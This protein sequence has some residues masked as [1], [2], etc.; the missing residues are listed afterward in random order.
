MAEDRPHASLGRV[1]I[2]VGGG[3]VFGVPLARLVAPQSS[4]LSTFSFSDALPLLIMS[5]GGACIVLGIYLHFGWPSPHHYVI[6]KWRKARL[7]TAYLPSVRVLG[8]EKRIARQKTHRVTGEDMKA[9]VDIGRLA[10]RAGVPERATPE[11]PTA[12]SAPIPRGLVLDPQLRRELTEGEKLLT[13]L[14]KVYGGKKSLGTPSSSGV[15]FFG[16]NPPRTRTPEEIRLS[17]H[18]EAVSEWTERVA[19]LLAKRSVELVDHF[20]G[21]T[22]QFRAVVLGSEELG[23]IADM[24]GLVA[25]LREIADGLV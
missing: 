11:A 21:E 6:A 9:L 24:R 15:G 12:Q 7:L 3:A 17:A 19:R 13:G 5:V 16:L 2:T 22:Q 18:S 8:P 14:E 20:L 25:R 10:E 1:L 4:T 23:L